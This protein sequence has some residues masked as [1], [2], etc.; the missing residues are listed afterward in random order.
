MCRDKG[1][2]LKRC[3]NPGKQC[4]MEVA[5]SS[6]CILLKINTLQEIF[7]HNTLNLTALGLTPILFRTRQAVKPTR[8]RAYKSIR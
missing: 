8:H 1:I 5:K 6:R 4:G 3:G 2:R 7:Y